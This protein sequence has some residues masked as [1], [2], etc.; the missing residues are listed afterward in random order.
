MH[1]AERARDHAVAAH[2]VKQAGGRGLRVHDVRDAHGHDVHDEQQLVEDGAAA[3]QS[4]VEEA[5]FGVDVLPV[6]LDERGNVGLRDEHDDHDAQSDDDALA[7]GLF[8]LLGFLSER[9]HTV[10][11]E[12]RQARDG[13]SRRDE[14]HIDLAGLV[15]RVHGELA[16]AA[17]TQDEV[18]AQ[19]DESD[20]REDLDC[21]DDPVDALL[22]GDASDVD[23]C[24]ERHEHEDPQIPGAS[25]DERYTPVRHHNQ[26]KRGD[27]DV[28]QKDQPAG[29]E[30]D[31][32]VDAALHIGVHGARDGE[33]LRHVHVAHCGE[34]DG[35]EAD[36]VHQ[37]GHTAG[38]L[39]NLTVNRLRRDDNHEQHA[40]E[41]DVFQRKAAAQ[42]LLVAE[43]LDSSAFCGDFLLCHFPS[44][45][46]LDRKT[47]ITQSQ[48]R[49]PALSNRIDFSTIKQ[50]IVH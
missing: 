9:G 5:H 44:F 37:R 47:S 35:D 15:D 27:E 20:D 2:G 30:A 18:R 16:G 42:L 38:F 28:V 34:A 13:A 49:Y 10:E 19:G 31:M 46:Y 3:G 29:N 36:D 14:V 11:A 7:D 8:G 43:G 6:G 21:E 33:A 25:R 23:D 41:N 48:K 50:W 39:L 1:L 4:G 45:H 40:V 22:H 32:G 12:E 17:T 26:K 24:V